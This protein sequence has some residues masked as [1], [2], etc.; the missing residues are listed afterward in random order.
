MLRFAIVFSISLAANAQ[1]PFASLDELRASMA[2][3]AE[4][5]EADPFWNRVLA[6]KAMPLVFDDDVVF[7][8][9][10][11]AD[12]VEWRGD[13]SSWEA[14]PE[15]RG[16]R[17]GKTDVWVYE[18]SFP[19]EARLDYKLVTDGATW[20]L[21]PLNPHT[22]MGGYGPNSEVRMPRWRAPGHVTRK[23]GVAR[24]TLTADIPFAS[25]KLGYSVN[26]RVYTPAGFDRATAKNLPVLYVTDGSDYWRDEMGSLVITLDNLIA[27]KRIVP[28]IAVF[29]DPWDRVTGVNRRE[30]ELVPAADRTCTFCEFLA[31][32][33]VPAI[34]AAYPTRASRDAR[35]ILGTSLGGLHATYMSTHNPPLFGLAGIQSPA[36]LAAPWVVDAI[37]RD[38]RL[39]R[40]AF[41]SAGT[42]ETG[43]A[44]SGRDLRDRFMRAGVD[45]KYIEVHEGHSWGQWRA[46][47]D[48]LL[49]FFFGS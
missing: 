39:P 17:L 49:L 10:G 35:A 33:L 48:D 3:V 21:D 27:A 42:F 43:F 18:R 7:L 40:K 34:D 8:W 36:L 47:L 5:G 26:Y 2:R 37:R 31:E 11:A 13:F 14:A 25:R 30:T 20:L 23:K 9:R 41:I 4:S 12:S 29:I 45:V 22:Q 24:G 28:L 46:L 6:H 1:T 15:T 38:A 32:E 16:K 44:E 19:L